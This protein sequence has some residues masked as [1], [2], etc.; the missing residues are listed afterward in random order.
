MHVSHLAC[1]RL[2]LYKPDHRLQDLGLSNLVIRHSS[3]SVSKIGTVAGVGRTLNF[4]CGHNV[5]YSTSRNPVP[6][7]TS[8][9]FGRFGQSYY[10]ASHSKNKAHLPIMHPSL[11]FPAMRSHAPTG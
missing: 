7:S 4:E 5:V 8:V 10:I 1:K 2:L 11:R 3:S 9:D 6:S